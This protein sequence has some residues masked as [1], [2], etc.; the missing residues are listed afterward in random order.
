MAGKAGM[1]G[2]IF[3]RINT[4]KIVEIADEMGLVKIAAVES[5]V[6]PGDGAAGGDVAKDTLKA[7]DATE[8]FWG[9]ADTLLEELDETARAEASLR[10][11]VGNAR[12]LRGY[13]KSRYGTVNGRMRV[14]TAGGAL[15]QSELDGAEF[16]G[17]CGSFQDTFAE[18]AGKAPPEIFEIKVNVKELIAGEF[19]KWHGARGTKGNADDKLLFVGI[20]G[21][22]FGPGAAESDATEF[23]DFSRIVGIVEAG[24]VFR[25]VDDE[26]HAAI[27]H[28]TLFG[29]GLRVVFVVP[30]DLDEVR[31]R[32]T[33]SED[34]AI[35]RE[36]IVRR[37]G[38]RKKKME[39]PTLRPRSRS[40]ERFHHRVSRG[41]VEFTQERTQD[42]PSK[43]EDGAPEGCLRR[44]EQCD[45]I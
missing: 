2:K 27:G 42:P 41:A 16:C 18:F 7:T 43:N 36:I 9:H 14:E 26:R 15:E 44:L 35:H 32:W 24:F 45:S 37:K 17:R 11:D 21:K 4:G 25:E 34:K 13:E 31:E 38:E 6:G 12:S 40:E 3:G 28:E 23:S 22:A 1:V 8:E 5:N 33:G 20:D 19:E 29:M 10:D 39:E 30:D